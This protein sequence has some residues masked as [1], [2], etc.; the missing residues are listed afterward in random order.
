MH[1][2]AVV[3]YVQVVAFEVDNPFP[4]AVLHVGIADIPLLWH[5]PIKYLGSAGNF[6]HLQRDFFIPS[7]AVLQ[8]K[9]SARRLAAY[10]KKS[11]WRCMKFPAEPKYLIGPCQSSGISAM[12]T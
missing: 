8:V 9:D 10:E 5:G 3:D 12:P 4:A 6:M 11:L 7:V 2:N 1:G